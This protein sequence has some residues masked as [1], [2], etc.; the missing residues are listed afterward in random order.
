[1]AE[2]L[3]SVE[4]EYCRSGQFKVFRQ[5]HPFL[6]GDGAR[7]A[8]REAAENLGMAEA[9]VRMAVTRLRRRYRDA[10]RKVVAE[11]VCDPKDIDAELRYLILTVVGPQEVIPR[12]VVAKIS[13]S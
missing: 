9:A 2:A 6:Q 12:E 5:L 4:A 13:T 10:L 11:T 3:K 1:L 8:Y 7:W